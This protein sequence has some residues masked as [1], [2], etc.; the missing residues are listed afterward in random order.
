MGSPWKASCAAVWICLLSS[1]LPAATP[2]DSL[3]PIEL[4]RIAIETGRGADGAFELAGRDAG[5]QLL[6]SGTDALGGTRDVTRSV[7]YTTEPAGVVE[8]DPTGHVRPLQEG[9]AT[10][11]VEVPAG[12]GARIRVDVRNIV[13]DKAVNF[14]NHVVPIFTKYGC[15]GG[16]CHGKSGGQNGFRLALLGFEPAEDYEFLTREAR[17]RRVFPAAPDRSLLLQKA[18][19]TVPHG[20]GQ[21]LELDSPAYRIVRRWIEQGMPYGDPDDPIVTHIAVWPKDRVM[22]QGSEQQLV[23]VAH[24]SDGSSEDVTRMTQFESNDAEMAE[25]GPTG[26][27]TTAELAGSVAVMARYQGFVDVFQ[28]TIPLGVQVENLPAPRNLVDEHVFAKLQRLGLPPSKTCDDATFLRRV[29]LDV[30]GRLPTLDETK[31]F[32]SDTSSDKR[33]SLID[34]LLSSDDYASYFATKW[35]GILRNKR[36]QDGDKSSTYAFYNWIRT[37]FYENKP[38]HQFVRE[39]VTASGEPAVNPPAAW[40]REVRD[41]AAQVEDTA[42]LFL[43]L[44][45]QCAR[46]HH[47]PFEAWSQQDYFGFAAFFAQL[48]RKKGLFD[49][50]IYHRPG[51]ARAQ[52]PK[53]GEDVPP[54]GLGS[55]PLEID[56]DDDPRIALADWMTDP[57]NPFF[58]KAAVNR[59]WK[60]FLGR[61]LVEPEDDMRV[62]NPP[63]NP[64]LLEALAEDFV[65]NEF[66][67]KHLIRTICSSQVY[68]LSSEPNKWN[69]DDKQNFSRFYPRR[70]HAEVLLDAVDQ[71]T[72]TTTDFAGMPAGTRAVE[73]PDNGFASTFLTV[74]G[75]PDSNSAC[76]CERSGD[77]NLAQSLQLL[78]SAEIL[79][80][81]TSAEAR[82]ARLS[83]E[84]AR[85]HEARLTELY[86]RAFAR[87]P[88]PD[89]L[90]VALDYIEESDDSQRA[91]EDIVWALINTKEFL[92]NH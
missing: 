58:A 62:T 51:V 1:L 10:I 90:S 73:L 23:V 40:Y 9:E 12:Q 55:Q 84:T 54:T 33:L 4:Q 37:S 83:G 71:L 76:E 52:N 88:E 43:G 89:E 61:G 14:P 39:I 46:C 6:V 3:R 92:F 44:R 26:L 74:F 16:G 49:D 17:G 5:Q 45:I 34:R 18:T 11:Q 42:Q 48:G 22:G 2:A 24:Y 77:A 47:H 59:Y 80:K 30:A 53:S 85:D 50:R 64:E 57:K 20:G 91:Y 56:P 19:A 60:H 63:S 31:Q 70:L 8:V 78:N 25:A 69:E 35:K 21:R 72:G 28:A 87:E 7:T 41:Q 79:T 81:L 27:V 67:L 82:P 15:N 86:L 13:R 38:Y 36:R 32:L 65:A 68:Q 75:R 66:D 29:T